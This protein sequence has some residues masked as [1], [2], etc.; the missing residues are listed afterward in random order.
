MLRDAQL[1]LDKVEDLSD[2]EPYR[3]GREEI[4]DG[5][6]LLND[7]HDSK[8]PYRARVVLLRRMNG[9]VA[10]LGSTVPRPSRELDE[11]SAAPSSSDGVA[12]AGYSARDLAD[13]YLSRWGA[14]ELRFR[15]INQATQ[16]KRNFGY[17][18][19]LVINAA[20]LNELDKARAYRNRLAE[21]IG[22]RQ[23]ELQSSRE[24]LKTA[25]LR[26]NAAKARQARQDSLVEL[27]LAV[28][29]TDKEAL[30]ARVESAKTERS[31]K[32]DA[33][34][35]LAQAEKCVA[36]TEAKLRKDKDR[37]PKLDVEIRDLE[38]RKEIY[39]A[40]V[41]LD[42]IATT[43]KLGFVLICEYMLR[44]FFGGLRISVATLMRQIL[45]LPGTR[46]I[47]GNVEHICLKAS[48]NKEIMAAVETACEHVNA[49]QIRRDRRLVKLSIDWGPPTR[50]RGRSQ[51]T[52]ANLKLSNGTG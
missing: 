19:R 29:H 42:R 48:P 52:S 38:S 39:Q 44:A 6:L 13:A 35:G 34:A 46:T 18:K 12:A 30:R 49:L 17:G 16:F 4:A 31:R 32:D 5:Y 47:E 43:W 15:A 21:R 9:D 28:T 37:L 51:I 1:R 10:V 25:K 7:S 20:V 41:E 23:A 36:N 24:A 11:A 26:L 3:D 2:W 33:M 22:R 8:V 14:Q 45:A 50:Q 27:E 40:D